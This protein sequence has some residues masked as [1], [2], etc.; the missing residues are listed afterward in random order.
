MNICLTLTRNE[1][2]YC[3]HLMSGTRG[4]TILMLSRIGANFFQSGF[5][6]RTG[7]LYSGTSFSG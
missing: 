1:F 4:E 3:A 2:Q 5:H 7:A 6:G